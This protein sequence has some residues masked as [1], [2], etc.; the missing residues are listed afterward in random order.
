MRCA[1]CNHVTIHPA[2]PIPLGPRDGFD[3][4]FDLPLFLVEPVGRELLWVWNQGHIDLLEAYLGA[5]L[6][7]RSNNPYHWSITSRLPRWMKFAGARHRVLH[8]LALL[9]ARA[10]REGLS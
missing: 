1:G 8:A 4:W 5:T 2:E 10:E 3:P 7:E 6:R 9:R